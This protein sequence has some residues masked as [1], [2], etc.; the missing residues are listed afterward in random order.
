[1]IRT[2]SS[3]LPHLFLWALVAL[4]L[5]TS[6][7]SIAQPVRAD[8]TG[9]CSGSVDFL[10]DSAGSYGPSNDTRS[11]PIVVPKTEGETAKWEGASPGD[12]RNHSGKVQIQIGPA[13]ITVADWGHP[14]DANVSAN[15]GDYAMDDFWAVVPG[16][17]DVV[18]G[19]YRARAD[20]AGDGASCA[21][22]AFIRFDGDPLSSPIV[23]GLIAVAVVLAG[24]VLMTVRR[25]RS[26]GLLGVAMFL[27][28]LLGL[29]LAGLLQQFSVWPL[30]NLS[31][32]GFPAIL[33]LLTFFL[34]R[35]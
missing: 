12:N 19:L 27:A 5:V 29:V 4:L 11:N 20:H 16:G 10:M 31:V 35:K 3:S 9:G 17:Q 32:F 30:D 8:V 25:A 21:A 23:L 7:L 14:N 2:R 1:M 13:W 15:S 28:I 34:R 18:N 6:M 24:L 33:V 26:G 22:V